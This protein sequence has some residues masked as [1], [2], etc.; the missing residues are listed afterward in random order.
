VFCPAHAFLRNLRGGFDTLGMTASAA[1]M[2][3]LPPTMRAWHILTADLLG[4]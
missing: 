4:R 2:A 3:L 1:T